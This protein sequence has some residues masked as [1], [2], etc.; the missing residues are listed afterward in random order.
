MVD[1]ALHREVLPLVQSTLFTDGACPVT[2]DLI[3]RVDVRT[4]TTTATTTAA[5]EARNLTT[6]YQV[7]IVDHCYSLCTAV[8]SIARAHDM[9]SRSYQL[10]VL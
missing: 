10:V 9:L 4:T 6:S 7:Y 1:A 5:L 2:T 8:S 3:M